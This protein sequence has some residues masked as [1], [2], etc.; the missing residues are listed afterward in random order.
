MLFIEISYLLIILLLNANIE[1]SYLFFFLEVLSGEPNW[2]PPPTKIADNK[3]TVHKIFNCVFKMISFIYLLRIFC[4]M[5][6][7]ERYE[8]SE[9]NCKILTLFISYRRL[10]IVGASCSICILSEVSLQYLTCTAFV[11]L[12]LSESLVSSV[13][14]S[15]APLLSFTTLKPSL[16]AML[17]KSWMRITNRAFVNLIR[18][19]KDWLGF[20]IYLIIIPSFTFIE[21]FLSCYSFILQ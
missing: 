9:N 5:R 2:P 6:K 1:Y 20:L 15:T 10:G 7:K 3:Y 11:F 19:S 18:Y 13:D 17:I 8:K 21:K 4:K 14:I 12:E 16:S